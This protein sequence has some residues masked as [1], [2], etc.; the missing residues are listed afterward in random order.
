MGQHNSSSASASPDAKT[1]LLISGT[2]QGNVGCAILEKHTALKRKLLLA[3]VVYER[4]EYRVLEAHHCKLPKQRFVGPGD[5]KKLN[6]IATKDKIKL[7]VIPG[8]ATPKQLAAAR[9]ECHE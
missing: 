5:I 4:T 6:Q 2:I 1:G 7:V 9:K 8:K 3:A